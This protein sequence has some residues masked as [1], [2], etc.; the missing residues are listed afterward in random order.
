MTGLWIETMNLPN[1]SSPRTASRELFFRNSNL[2][3]PFVG[4]LGFPDQGLKLEDLLVRAEWWMAQRTVHKSK[5]VHT[6]GIRYLCRKRVGRP[7]LVAAGQDDPCQ[8]KA[9][10]STHL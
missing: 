6:G 7:S 1:G 4:F 5:F 9:A 3:P 2:V 10:C 8:N